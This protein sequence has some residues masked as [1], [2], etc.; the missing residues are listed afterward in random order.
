MA[1]RY[2][3]PPINFE[4][5]DIHQIDMFIKP[6]DKE[7][8]SI[9]LN[10][11]KTLSIDLQAVRMG[12]DIRSH[13]AGEYVVTPRL[14]SQELKTGAK[15]CSDDITVLQIPVAKVSNSHGGKTATIG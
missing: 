7:C 2:I 5:Q 14:F 15:V 13:Y 3:I 12:A 10:P 6:I 11:V 8:I 9:S 4:I 1:T